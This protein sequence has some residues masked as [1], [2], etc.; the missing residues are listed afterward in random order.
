MIITKK[1]FILKDW[2]SLCFNLIRLN[3]PFIPTNKSIYLKPDVETDFSI[4]GFNL[5][6]LVHL[7]S[8]IKLRS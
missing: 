7:R 8:N 5:V 4:Y 1:S 6:S 2:I 3:K